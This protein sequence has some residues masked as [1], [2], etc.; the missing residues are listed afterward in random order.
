MRT[1][2]HGCEEANMKLSTRSY[3]LTYVVIEDE[4]DQTWGFIGF[5]ADREAQFIGTKRDCIQWI[6]N[7]YEEG[8]WKVIALKDYD[9]NYDMEEINA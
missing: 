2:N 4:V 5:D 9:T 7:N 1:T 8:S 6:I 3:Q